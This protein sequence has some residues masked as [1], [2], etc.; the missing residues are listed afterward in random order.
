MPSKMKMKIWKSRNFTDIT[1][2]FILG[3]S[4]IFRGDK[5]IICYLLN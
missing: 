1:M 2:Q 5:N 3:G 4:P